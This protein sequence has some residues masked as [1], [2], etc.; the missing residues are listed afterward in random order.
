MTDI[1]I[2]QIAIE[3]RKRKDYGDLGPLVESIKRHGVIEPIV[4]VKRGEKYLL[5][6]GERRIRASALAGR[7]SVPIIL[8]NELD[9]LSRRELE[10][11][12]NLYR[13]DLTWPEQVEL[14]AQI[15]KLKR[16][17]YG[18]G[19]RGKIDNEGWTGVKTAE[20][21]G[22]SKGTLYEDLKLADW[23][24][25][26]PEDRETLGKLP[27]RA[28]LRKIM[29]EMDARRCRENL[30]SSSFKPM[31]NFKLGDA[32]KLIK[33]VP[34]ES[35]DMIL[36]DPPYASQSLK[37]AEDTAKQVLMKE[38][39]NLADGGLELFCSISDD[40]YR[41]LKPGRHIYVFGSI[42]TCHHFTQMLYES[43]FT[44]PRV[45]LIWNK[46][47]NQTG[48]TGLNYM[49]SYEVIIWGYKPT[50]GPQIRPLAAPACDVISYSPLTSL[51]R[52]HAFE[53]PPALLRFLMSQSSCEY[54]TIFD[55][56]AGVASVLREA[57]HMNR[58][59]LSFELDETHY[60]R[61]RDLLE[62]G[63]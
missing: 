21:L 9:E 22:I 3:D 41:V 10:L 24:K 51:A 23:I 56:F 39:D 7:A 55:P 16:E 45:P 54:E 52:H 19:A 26:N 61:G 59:S 32:R 36:T 53:K 42:E 20:S 43:G 5:I 47:T 46:M 38:A 14:R 33:D 62:K 8:R 35:M 18:S 48:F 44:L 57:L 12:E 34:S 60:Q 4:V 1:Q 25:N 49:R 30:A 13:K 58:R 2:S 28:A 40:L 6:A 11:E 29:Q 27:K 31:E 63:M 50:L 37:G 15:D 17:K